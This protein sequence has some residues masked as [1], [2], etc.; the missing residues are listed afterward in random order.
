MAYST[1]SE[2]EGE[3]KS[4]TFGADTNVTETA[5]NAFIDEADA[6]IDTHVGARYTV[7]ISGG[8]PVALKLMKLF[9]R[10]LVVARVKPILN[11]KQL[12]N[13][14]ANQNPRGPTTFD[15][16]DVMKM[17]RDIRDGKTNLSDATPLQVGGGFSS[18]NRSNDIQPVM[19][20][21]EK[22]W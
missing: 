2:I 16:D 18:Y 19:K 4:I 15:V 1:K 9:S 21:D 5:V 8:S 10:T 20:K 11:V 6:L 12:S 14:D 22:Q 13:T 17:L 7:P 3:F